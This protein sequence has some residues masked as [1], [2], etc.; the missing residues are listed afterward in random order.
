MLGK[1]LKKPTDEQIRK[2]M[3]KKREKIIHQATMLRK[4][5]ND[6]SSG[7]REYVD[8]LEEYVQA[9]KKRKAI[10]SLHNADEKTLQQLRQLDHE[11][12]FINTFILQ[13]PNKMFKL[14]NTAE[15]KDNGND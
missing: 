2:E 13:I 8:L 14:E 6:P 1:F 10:T 7:W 5:T 9:C 3:E 12:W 4:L 11:V 15:E